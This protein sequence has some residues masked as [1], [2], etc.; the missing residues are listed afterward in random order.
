MNIHLYVDDPKLSSKTAPELDSEQIAADDTSIEIDQEQQLENIKR[1]LKS[2][3]AES[4]KS[5][6]PSTS[7]ATKIDNDD[8]DAEFNFEDEK[9]QERKRKL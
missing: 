3:K 8:D 5:W 4:K 9:N 7:T 1:K 2:F 6:L